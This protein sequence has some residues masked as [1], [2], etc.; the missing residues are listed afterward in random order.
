ML[1]T[2]TSAEPGRLTVATEAFI[3][4]S[5]TGNRVVRKQGR[6]Q[7]LPGHQ[8]ELAGFP[9]GTGATAASRW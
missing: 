5:F 6:L 9:L 8:D 4:S 7:S 1:P 2:Y 3:P